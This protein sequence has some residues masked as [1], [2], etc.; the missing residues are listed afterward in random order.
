MRELCGLAART[1]GLT[2]PRAA[3][4]LDNAASRAVLTRPWFVRTG[5]TR[6]DGRPG[7][8]YLRAL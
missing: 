6:L 1:Y 3:A 2:A 7:P 8:T 5:E 4:T